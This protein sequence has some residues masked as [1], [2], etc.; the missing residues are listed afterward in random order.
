MMR[1]RGFY[2]GP[3]NLA[4]GSVR[5][6]GRWGVIIQQYGSFHKLYAREMFMEKI[7]N[8]SYP[9]LPSRLASNFL[10]H[11]I[12][13]AIWYQS[14][15]HPNDVI[16]NVLFDS[17]TYAYHQGQI[18]CIPPHS[19]FTDEEATHHYWMA[20]ALVSETGGSELTPWEVVTL[21]PMTIVAEHQ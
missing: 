16:Y 14:K 4:Q 18:L 7:R 1:T 15:H 12:E 5:Q 13:D 9:H 21:S 10:C 17:E 8:K 20:D 6:P 11:R 2:V 19:S 3:A